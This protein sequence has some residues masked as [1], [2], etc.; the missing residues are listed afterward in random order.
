[1][2]PLAERMGREGCGRV[3]FFVPTLLLH[4]SRA[5]KMITDGGFS[6]AAVASALNFGYR[7]VQTGYELQAVRE[8]R[9]TS[10]PPLRPRP[11]TS[12]LRGRCAGGSLEY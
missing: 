6:V 4:H 9:R 8:R 3:V 1:M 7:S 10:W 11:E 12:S 2:A 5:A